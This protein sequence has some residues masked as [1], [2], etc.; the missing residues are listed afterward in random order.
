MINF[1]FNRKAT[2]NIYKLT[3][4]NLEKF[5]SVL[6]YFSYLHV[7]GVSDK[8]FEALV[9]HA[10]SIF[11]ENEVEIIIQETLERKFIKFFH[12]KFAASAEEIEDIESAIYL[13]DVSRK[14]KSR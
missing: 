10:C 7:N 3:N 12:S 11:L 4:S 13:L 2:N 5:K 1:E 9:R 8:A 6:S 14:I